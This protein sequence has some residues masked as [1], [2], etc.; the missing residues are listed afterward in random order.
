MTSARVIAE[1]E[2]R[3]TAFE[4]KQAER[5]ARD[6]TTALAIPIAAAREARCAG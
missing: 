5:F 4:E 2:Q 3:E 6:I 1:E